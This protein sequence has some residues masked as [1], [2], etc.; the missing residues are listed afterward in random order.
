MASDGQMIRPD[1]P[2]PFEL[3]NR[4]GCYEPNDNRAYGGP[5]DGGV[6]E[7][8]SDGPNTVM[9]KFGGHLGP[10]RADHCNGLY[11]VYQRRQNPVTAC[12][13]AWVYLGVK[14][15]RDMETGGAGR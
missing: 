10:G 7:M 3:S 1:G 12:G 2:Q 13:D 11:H 5:H 8:S 15:Q 6:L 14:S 9:F 4:D